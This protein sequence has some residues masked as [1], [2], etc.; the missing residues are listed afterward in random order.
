[1]TEPGLVDWLSNLIGGA[2]TTLVGAAI[3]RLMWHSGEVRKGQRRFFSREL[4]WEIPV[5]FGMAFIGEA[6]ASYLGA[7]ATVGTGIVALA[8]YYGPRGA[9]VLLAKWLTRA[10]P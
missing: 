8:A 1:M 2:A 7:N 3:G 5:V 6:I 4:L 9:E 10:K